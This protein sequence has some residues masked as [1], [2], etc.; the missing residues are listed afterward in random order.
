MRF[1]PTSS[2]EIGAVLFRV[3][4]AVAWFLSGRIILLHVGREEYGFVSVMMSVAAWLQMFDFGTTSYLRSELPKVLATDGATGAGG[5]F[6]RA[7]VATTLSAGSILLVC[8][9][10]LLL[11]PAAAGHLIDVLSFDRVVDARLFAIS[12]AGLSCYAFMLICGNL[13][14]AYLAAFHRQYVFFA[15]GIL[16]CVAGPFAT[17]WGVTHHQNLGTLFLLF[18]LT[19]LIPGFVFFLVTIGRVIRSAPSATAF[20]P[21]NKTAISFLLIQF[22]GAITSNLDLVL[23]SHYFG[24]GQAAVYSIFKL[25]IQFPISLHAQFNLQSWPVYSLLSSMPSQYPRVRDLVMRNNRLAIGASVLLTAGLTTLGPWF[26][27]FWSK[28]ELESGHLTA[29]L[30]SL[31]GSVFMISNTFAMLMFSVNYT[32][33]LLPL[34]WISPPAFV[35]LVFL[36]KTLGP[37]AVILSNAIVCAFGLVVGLSFFFRTS[38]SQSLVLSHPR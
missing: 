9:L 22:G 26:V 28:G 14:Q 16:G 11:A 30:F 18:C 19:P 33:G 21:F 36:M 10:G 1:R 8:N 24:L 25:V 23:V 29:G 31:Y 4:Q 27:H 17:E 20:R 37:D 38:K 5:Y 15:L 13:L 3:A 12:V 7:V 34:A 32:R 35:L 2:N 6:R